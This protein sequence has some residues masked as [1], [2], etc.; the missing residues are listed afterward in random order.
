MN[1]NGEL[2]TTQELNEKLAELCGFTRGHLPRQVETS[3][4]KNGIRVCL[5]GDWNPCE[6]LKQL[7]MCYEALSDYEKASFVF[8]NR[9]AP[10]GWVFTHT[11]LVAQAI[12][13]AKEGK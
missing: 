13:N 2:M 8:D 1:K 3:Y 12:L 9:H 5:V 7:K 11:E 10:T 4:F 6:D